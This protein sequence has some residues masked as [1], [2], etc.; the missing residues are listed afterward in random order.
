MRGPSGTPGWLLFVFIVL[1]LFS[2]FFSDS[3]LLRI[4]ATLGV[5]LGI[6]ALASGR[7]LKRE[8]EETESDLGRPLRPFEQA[9]AETVGERMLPYI[10]VGA[11]V[12]LVVSL[13][14]Y[15]GRLI[16]FW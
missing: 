16:G 3:L 8:S 10:F 5:I 2:A 6:G 7:R 15:A 13:A 12:L 11:A 14:L 9:P 4:L 1:L